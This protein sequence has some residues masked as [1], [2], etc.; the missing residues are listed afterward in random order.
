MAQ[1]AV[2]SAEKIEET[3]KAIEDL[4]LTVEENK[5]RSQ[6]AAELARESETGAGK[7]A[8]EIKK[9]IEAISDMANRTKEITSAMDIIDDIAFQTNL[10]ALN[11]AVEAARAGEQGKGFAVVAEAVRNLALKSAQAAKEVKTV[12]TGSVDQTHQGLALARASDKVLDGILQSVQK[13]NVLNQEIAQTTS[14]QSE[15]IHAIHGAMNALE[16]QTQAFSAA[17]EETAAT[18]EEMSAQANTLKS[19]VQNMAREV[20]GKQ[21][22]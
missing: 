22:S 4:R 13:V 2:E 21:A 18:S 1:G 7:G 14:H 15:G 12:I 20:T 10:L 17:A 11:A 5:T 16:K 8:N 9:L 3:L 6:T 19:M